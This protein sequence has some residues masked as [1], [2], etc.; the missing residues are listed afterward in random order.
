[1]LFALHEWVNELESRIYRHVVK[2]NVSLARETIPP[3][4]RVLTF[5]QSVDTVSL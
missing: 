4:R 5:A 2:G 3:E 1:M